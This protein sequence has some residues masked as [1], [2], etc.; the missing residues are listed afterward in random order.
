M[1]HSM[2]TVF[3]AQMCAGQMG[4][5]KGGEDGLHKCKDVCIT[6]KQ[7][8]CKSARVVIVKHRCTVTHQFVPL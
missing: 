2:N 5:A 7:I 1:L 4:K 3:P 6:D 8:L